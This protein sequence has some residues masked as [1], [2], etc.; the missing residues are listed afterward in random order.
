[1]RGLENFRVFDGD[2]S[3]EML[4]DHLT[5]GDV[6]ITKTTDLNEIEFGENSHLSDLIIH[7]SGKNNKISI[8]KNVS[9]SGSGIYISGDNNTVIIGDNC[10]LKGAFFICKGDNNGVILGDG[11]TVSGEFWGYVHF[12]VMESTKIS[13]GSDSMLSGNIIIRTTDGHAIIDENLRRLN[14]PRDVNLGKHVWVGMNVAILKGCSVPDNSIIGANSVVTKSF[15]EEVG[16]TIVIAGNPAR[17]V[18]KD[19]LYWVRTR[20]YVFKPEDYKL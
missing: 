5:D 3:I 8:G 6:L 9:F 19:K 15:Q 4:H 18:K 14:L 16:Y 10:K 7:T 12:H 2:F 11:V 1:M 20:G 13:I 17:V